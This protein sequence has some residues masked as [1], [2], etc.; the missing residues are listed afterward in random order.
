MLSNIPDKL[1]QLLLSELPGKALNLI[2]IDL[3]IGQ[4]HI[5]GGQAFLCAVDGPVDHALRPVAGVHV[6]RDGIGG[7]GGGLDLVDDHRAV[8]IGKNA[9]SPALKGK[10]DALCLPLYGE[11]YLSL[12]AVS[13]SFLQ[14]AVDV[15]TFQCTVKP[16]KPAVNAAG[17]QQKFHQLPDGQ[18]DACQGVSPPFFRYPTP[19]SSMHW[20]A[21]AS[22][23]AKSTAVR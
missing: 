16:R 7:R 10:S 6:L 13:G 2:G 19:N 23:C 20:A 5:H 1:R 17:P 15:G 18:M 11:K 14:F 9:V 4:P 22:T 21:A 12:I 3:I 8:L